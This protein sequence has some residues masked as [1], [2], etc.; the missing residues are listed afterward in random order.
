MRVTLFD[1]AKSPPG[2]SL[3]IS[4]ARFLDLISDIENA[5]SLLCKSKAEKLRGSGFACVQY[6]EGATRKLLSELDRASETEVFVF[7]VDEMTLEEIAEA[8]PTWSEYSSALY[9]TWKH[10]PEAPRFRLLVELSEPVP[11]FNK[12]PVLGL[13]LAAAAKLG[14]KFD[15][16][17]FDRARLSFGPQHSPGIEP[18][19]HRFEG[20]PLNIKELA[21]L[22]QTERAREKGVES[23]DVTGDRPSRQEVKRLAAAWRRSRDERRSKLGSALEAA[24]RGDAYAPSGSMHNTSINLAFELVREVPRLD[25]DWFGSEYLA[26]SWAAMGVEDGAPDKWRTSVESARDKLEASRRADSEASSR[27]KVDGTSEELSEDALAGVEAMRGKLIV[28]YRR[29]YYVY[30][31]RCGSY[32]GPFAGTEV[33][34]AV[35]DLLGGV[36]GVTELD[37]SKGSPILK[38]AVALCHEYGC[39]CDNVIYYAKRPKVAWDESA[40][41]VCIQAYKWIDW[42]AVRHTIAE[43]LLEAMGGEHLDQ[44]LVYL[45]K[46]RDLGQPLPALAM[47]GPRGTW[48]SRVCE[49]LSRFWTSPDSVNACKA[50]KVMNRFNAGLLKNPIVWSDEALAVTWQNKPKPEA[51]RE[52]ITAT[53]HQLEPKGIETVTLMSAVRHMISVNDDSKIFSSEVDA[54]SVYATMERFL[55]VY[56]KAPALSAF[57]DKWR[58]TEE[59][60]R[61]RSGETL[62]EHVRWLEETVSARS[63][64]RLFVVPHTD[65]E[66]L[67]RARFSDETLH[68]IWAICFEAIKHSET[69]AAL[70]SRLPLFVED[71]KLRISPA[72]VSDLWSLSKKVEGSGVRKPTAQRIG[73]I[74]SLAGFK[75]FKEERASKNKSGAWEVDEETLKRFIDVSDLPDGEVLLQYIYTDP[76]QK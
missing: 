10:T 25:G 53:S 34:V 40:E 52:S 1:S 37:W 20:K 74:L 58:G 63:E 68:Y 65:A 56:T 30:N 2:D 73:R 11:N 12:E 39:T 49:V 17:T 48:K 13:Y 6:R 69:S 5:P 31:A 50:D 66:V 3:E 41:A 35:R 55:L 33:A 26:G 14:V 57:E 24:L 19:R 51:Y 70:N 27:F 29:S 18:E 43:E 75:R 71:G 21:P 67:M 36:P 42:P 16:N 9:S 8:L 28:S 32:K 64:G 62:L 7:D 23:F 45:S 44:L 4:G 59:L 22:A 46:F 15:P 60:D 72:R 47:V 76:K 54:D 61:L 38:S